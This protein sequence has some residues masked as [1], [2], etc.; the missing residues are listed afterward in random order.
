MSADIL[1]YDPDIVPV[2][3]DQKQ[4]VEFARDTA[5]KF[6]GIFGETFSLPD[7]YTPKAIA[8]IPGL[9]GQKM[10]K[11]Y[12]NTIPLFASD[13]VIRKQVMSIVTDSKGV[14]DRKDPETCN[15]FALHKHFSQNDLDSIKK[16][17]TE[18]GIGYKES[19][20]ILADNI[21]ASITP[22]RK[23]RKALEGDTDTVKHIL[24]SG[25]EK[26]QQIA[27]KKMEVVR[28]NIGATL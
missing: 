4:H 24:K 1:L 16:R 12:N 15:V 5:E 3:A 11:T 27:Q 9:D 26:A 18:G 10:S 7:V 13:E 23:K 20:D 25:K 19:K 21:I 8:I 22:L 6:N 14:E 28:K 2:G 17:Y